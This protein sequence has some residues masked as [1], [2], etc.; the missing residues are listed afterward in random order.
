MSDGKDGAER[1]V[2]DVLAAIRAR[3]QAEEAGLSAQ[4]QPDGT[5]PMRL[6]ADQQ[7]EDTDTAPTLRRDQPAPMRLDTPVDLPKLRL[8][9]P[10]PADDDTAM[11][12][13]TPEMEHVPE[14]RHIDVE[15]PEE[16]P[17]SAT[18]T[19]LF[20]SQPE[21]MVMPDAETALDFE[22]TA[23]PEDEGLDG[24]EFDVVG[25][26]ERFEAEEAALLED[27]VHGAPV[28]EQMPDPETAEPSEG[29]DVWNPQPN[30]APAEYD[31][32]TPQAYPDAVA[33]P[34]IAPSPTG[35]DAETIRAIVRE[36]LA[37]Q[38]VDGDDEVRAEIRGIVAEELD[39]EL[40]EAL[41]KSIRKTIRKDI[42]RAFKDRGLN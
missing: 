23:A 38:A 30:A 35:V 22:D 17:R 12:G 36:I 15:D 5:P 31:V 39:G 2:S 16:A 8:G 14:A 25:E 26:D 19:P 1:S 41:A 37:E 32:W 13:D 10:V 4:P 40:G 3:V 21:A 33:D 27:T 34:V 42:V 24:P 9:D 29:Y 7:V 28:A 11:R 6:T 18:V 20:A